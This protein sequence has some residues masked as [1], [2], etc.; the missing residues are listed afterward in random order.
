MDWL[1]VIFGLALGGALVAFGWWLGFRLGHMEGEE[2]GYDTGHADGFN[3][4]RLA[5]G[6]GATGPTGPTGADRRYPGPTGP[7]YWTH[8]PV[9]PPSRTG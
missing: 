8:A 4:G 9:D 5:P 6:T 3:A 1:S 2:S 7:G